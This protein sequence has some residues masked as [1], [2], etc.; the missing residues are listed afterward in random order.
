[1]PPLPVVVFV[2]DA[3]VGKTSI[4]KSWRKDSSPTAQTVFSSDCEVTI[5]V[6]GTEVAFHVKDTA[7]QETYRSLV[8]SYCRN[9]VVVVVVCAVKAKKSIDS[10]PSWV[11]FVRENA[12]SPAIVVVRNKCDLAEPDSLEPM[13]EIVDGLDVFDTSALTGEA[14]PELFKQIANLVLENP[15]QA[16]ETV[17]KAKKECFC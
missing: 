2:G 6:N 16:Q 4:I 14:I 13:D 12:N 1:M 11:D 9:A 3:C 17:H 15:I 10:I 5:N 7:G 8:P